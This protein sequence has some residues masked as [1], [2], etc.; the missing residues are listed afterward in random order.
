MPT[1]KQPIWG[2]SPVSQK[3]KTGFWNTIS[4]G[5]LYPAEVLLSAQGKKDKFQHSL[6]EVYVGFILGLNV[7]VINIDN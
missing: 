6:T 4:R 1:V 5:T 3:K 7:W 2:L